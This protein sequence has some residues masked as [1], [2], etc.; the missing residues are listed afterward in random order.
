V[1]TVQQTRGGQGMTR[2]DGQ[3]SWRRGG[4]IGGRACG[5]ISKAACSESWLASKASE[6]PP[7]EASACEKKRPHRSCGAESSD[8]ACL[9]LKAGTCA[10]SRHHALIT[11]VAEEKPLYKK[12]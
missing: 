7:Y 10:E 2:G 5:I 9:R 3:R 8:F 11:C 12:A 4:R 1:K 6:A